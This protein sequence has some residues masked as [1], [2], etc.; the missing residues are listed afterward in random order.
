MESDQASRFDQQLQE[1]QL[2]LEQQGGWAADL[3]RRWKSM[4]HY[5]QGK[6][7]MSNDTMGRSAKSRLWETT[8]STQC[9]FFLKYTTRVGAGERR[10]KGEERFKRHI[11]SFCKTGNYLD[12]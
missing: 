9:S 10:A 3:Q 2:T 4:C 8:Q 1:V 12:P 7:N 5:I 11:N 6:R